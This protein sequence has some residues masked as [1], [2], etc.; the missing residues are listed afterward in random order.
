MIAPLRLYSIA[1]AAGVVG[2]AGLFYFLRSRRKTPE[3]LER[4]RRQRIATFGRITDGTVMDACEIANAAGA[5]ASQLLIFHYDVAGVTYEASQD[6][7]T[8]RQF[9]DLHTCRLGLPA[10]V[11]YDPQNPGNSIVI[12]EGWTGLRKWNAPQA[13]AAEESAQTQNA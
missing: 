5:P 7:T 4:E 10:S 1:L 13:A 8:L 11:K 3:Q 9:V 12:A 6:V 2:A